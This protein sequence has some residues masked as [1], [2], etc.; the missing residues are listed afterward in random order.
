MSSS[1]WSIAFKLGVDQSKSIGENLNTAKL[2]ANHQRAATR[3]ATAAVRPG[4]KNRI[5][6]HTRGAWWEYAA[7]GSRGKAVSTH[8]KLLITNDKILTVEIKVNIK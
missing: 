8:Y 2:I 5:N 7:R 1:Y 6:N 3:L 4:I